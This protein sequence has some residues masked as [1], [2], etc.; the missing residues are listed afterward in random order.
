MKAVGRDAAGYS[1]HGVINIPDGEGGIEVGD[2][3]MMISA[4]PPQHTGLRKLV[5]PEFIPRAARAM[6][7]RI[8]ELAGRIIDGVAH[9]G[10]CDL[11][12]DIAG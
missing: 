12:E 8:E 10:E 11:V 1:S 3:E 5:A 7:P 2:H 9:R 6:R 4:D